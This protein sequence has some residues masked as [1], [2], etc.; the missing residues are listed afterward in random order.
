MCIAS[1]HFV[2]VHLPTCTMKA[3]N[4]FCFVAS[5]TMEAY[6]CVG[7]QIFVNL[8]HEGIEEA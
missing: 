3:S 8:C 6:Y 2:S 5:K 4:G 7:N 1:I